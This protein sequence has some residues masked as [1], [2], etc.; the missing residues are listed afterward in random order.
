[1]VVV[2]RGAHFQPGDRVYGVCEVPREGA[3][4]QKIAIRQ[5]IVAG[6]PEKLTDVQTA[7]SALTGLTA[8]ISIEETLHLK[9]GETILLQ[10]AGVAKDR[11]D[12]IAAQGGSRPSAS[13]SRGEAGERWDDTAAADHRIS[14]GE[15]GRCAAGQRSASP[16]RQAGAA[17]RIIARA[18]DGIAAAR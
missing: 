16:A 2:T 17:G 1:G 18:G 8:L 5:A 9:R 6:K 15:G 10:G 4:A 14:A 3:Y 12:L 7:A 11:R 13:G